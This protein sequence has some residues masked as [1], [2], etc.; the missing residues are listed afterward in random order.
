M[1]DTEKTR[2][3]PAEPQASAPPPA[4]EPVEEAP[5]QKGW[6]PKG[7]R[8]RK[9]VFALVI[10]AGALAATLRIASGFDAFLVQAA[11]LGVRR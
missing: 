7:S 5:Q 4:V 3:V 10:L 9:I 1:T 11:A 2:P 8:R 6:A